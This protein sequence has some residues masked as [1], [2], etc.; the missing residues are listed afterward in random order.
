MGIRFG[1]DVGRKTLVVHLLAKGRELRCGI[2]R[3][4]WKVLT[5][6]RKTPRHT[7][8]HTLLREN[9]AWVPA[10]NGTTGLSLGRCYRAGR[11]GQPGE[12]WG[13]GCWQLM[14]QVSL[15]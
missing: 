1:D 9:G 14:S 13:G 4:N 10:S 6:D 12:E 3:S 11:L 2:D 5:D 15:H 8:R 7:Q